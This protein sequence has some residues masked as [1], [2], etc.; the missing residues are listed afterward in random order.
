MTTIDIINKLNLSDEKKL[1][2][3]A[4]YVDLPG[5]DASFK[6]TSPRSCDLQDFI[7]DV[8]NED[9]QDAGTCCPSG[10]PGERGEPGI[11]DDDDIKTRYDELLAPLED[12]GSLAAFPEDANFVGFRDS[13]EADHLFLDIPV[14][15]EV[16][17]AWITIMQCPDDPELPPPGT[18]IRSFRRRL[19]NSD[20]LQLG[21]ALVSAEGG[22]FIDVY[23]EK[24]E[25]IVY[26]HKPIRD[27]AFLEGRTKLNLQYN[28]R[29]FEVAIIQPTKLRI[30]D[31][32]K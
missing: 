21:V 26:E 12:L 14:P 23:L 6:V 16:L 29:S 30:G 8:F 32:I 10:P 28:D 4:L 1:K 25:D 2:L 24:G 13:L 19:R 15:R 20:N 31:P 3:L 22:P 11:P 7:D 17:D 27:T 5:L 18:T 9:Q